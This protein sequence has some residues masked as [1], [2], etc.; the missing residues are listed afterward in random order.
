MSMTRRCLVALI[1]C[2][3]AACAQEVY[4]G[5]DVEFA[6]GGFADIT[7]PENQDRITDLVWITRGNAQGIFNIAQEESFQDQGIPSPSPVGTRWAVGSAADW[8]SLLFGTWGDVHGGKPP[9]LVGQDL[10]MHLVDDDIYI[11]VRFTA[12]GQG[13][14][15]GGSFAYRRSAIPGGC[16]AADIAAPFG[17]LDLGDISAFI[18][19][20]LAGEPAADLAPPA[21]VFDLADLSAFV[22]A[23]V[24]GCP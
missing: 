7:L 13:P 19:A 4:T 6:K 9:S 21:G 12:W 18:G 22:N 15:A 8:A 24:G 14:P 1:V 23:F 3:G 2:A 10:V 5:L 11:D 16:N 17:V 20:F